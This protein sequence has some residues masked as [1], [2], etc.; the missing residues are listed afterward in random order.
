MVFFVSGVL[1]ACEHFIFAPKMLGIINNINSD[2]LNSNSVN[3]MTPWAKR[4]LL[5]I[6]LAVARH[7]GVVPLYWSSLEDYFNLGKSVA[8]GVVY[9]LV[10]T[11]RVLFSGYPLHNL[12]HVLHLLKVDVILFYYEACVVFALHHMYYRSRAGQYQSS[13]TNLPPYMHPAPNA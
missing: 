10:C 4:V 7:P 13:R 8:C 5:Y 2:L 12:F 11:V 9:G 6:R 3:D 1:G